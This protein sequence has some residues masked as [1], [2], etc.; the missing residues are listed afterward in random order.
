MIGRRPVPTGR[1]TLLS[2]Y[3]ETLGEL[4]LRKQT[5]LALMASKLETEL[6][7]R[8]KS[9]FLGT[10]SHELRTPLNAIIGFSE[11]ITSMGPADLADAKAAEYSEQITKAGRHMLGVIS[12]ILDIS[13]IESGTF[14]L[15]IDAYPVAEIIED[16]LPLVRERIAAKHQ[17]L[18]VRMGRNLPEIEVDARR[19]RQILLNLLTNASKFTPERGR[20][21]FVARRTKD[22]GATIAVADSGIGMTPDQMATAMTP[23]GQIHS[24]LSRSEEGTGLGLPIARGLA[25]QHGGDLYIESEPGKGTT[26]VLTLRASAADPLGTVLTLA[27]GGGERSKARKATATT[28]KDGKS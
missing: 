12:D 7:S 10:M 25:R 8:A 18:E 24:H 21:I 6:A 23:F 9:S 28:P 1:Q 16:T 20:I 14:Q 13:K 4:S 3:C 2:R 22:G 17:V 27:P 15:N 5:E 11:I 19:I 26:V